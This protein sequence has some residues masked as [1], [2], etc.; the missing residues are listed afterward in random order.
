MAT[1]NK[2]LNTR[3]KLKRDTS[4]NWTSNNPVL[5]NGEII[6]VDTAEG[7]VRFKIGDGSKTYTQ[8]PF[9]D[10]GIRNLIADKSKVVV[11]TWLDSSEPTAQFLSELVI[12]KVKDRETYEAMVDAGKVDINELY[13]IEE[14]DELEI[15]THT[16]TGTKIATIKIGANETDIYA[17][18]GGI[19]EI[20]AKDGLESSGATGSITLTNAGVRDIVQDSVDGHKLTI[21]TNGVNKIITIPDNNTTYAAGSGLTLDGT[22]FKHTNSITAK[23]TQTQS[24][25]APGYNGTFTITE[26]KYDA[27]GHITGVATAT[28]TMPKEQDLSTY[29]KKTEL[30]SGNIVV[31]KATTASGLDATGVNQV[32]AIKVD[33]AAAADTA[34]TANHATTADTATT[35]NKTA[36]ALTI[37]SKI[38]NGST[39]ITVA[40]SDLG[41]EQV[42][43]FKGSV[44]SLSTSNNTL[45][46]VVLYNGFEYVW[47]GT[48]WEQLGQEGSFSL[49]THTHQVIHKPEG[50]ISQPTFTGTQAT[51][52]SS[53]TP[54]GTV[55]TPT[56]TGTKF[57]HSHEF[58]GDQAT[59][60]VD[61]TPE[62]TV[63]K[64][65]FTGSAVD[66]NAA[67][68]AS[69]HTAS[70]K[71][72]SS[73]GTLPSASLTAGTAPSATFS[74]GSL[75]KTVST[76]GPNRRMTLTYTAPSH[77][78]NAGT[79]PTLTFNAG[80]LPTLGN[81][82][83]VSTS[84]HK[85]SVTAA[86]SVSQ[87]TFTGTADSVSSTYIPTGTIEEV[88]I[89]PAG[90]ISQ[91]TF[92]G[93]AGTATATYTPAGSV[94]QPT[95]T[96][97]SATITT[98]QAN[99]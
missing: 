2:V 50:T 81:A 60:T 39:N 26:P 82:I 73:V 92:T 85:H 95:F 79:Y 13:F 12:N 16:T 56:F 20:I 66:S 74:A 65:T 94:S 29:A 44:S 67:T 80:T 17:P 69:G 58:V 38:F 46:D 25:S 83:T 47:T 40:A 19:T 33:S 35:A 21:N 88:E 86:G 31:S 3:I 89:T 97:T 43:R 5:L 9:D 76:S 14:D 41:L 36:G 98:A 90:T 24:T 75:T 63:S 62:G 77:S 91:P 7:E 53:Y 11:E 61:F 45:G 30:T 84:S 99:A 49:K 1:E 78:F 37:G 15:I 55:S 52:N 72:V 23:T 93:T 34:T 4:A 64:P 48:E 6:I 59:I 71:P 42:M 8:L 96:G 57:A 10:E 70:I 87:P 18:E 28:I 51:I 22:T 32:K 27:Q 54:T 68:T